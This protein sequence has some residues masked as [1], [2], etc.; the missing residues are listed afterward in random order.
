MFTDLVNTVF[1]GDTPQ[2]PLALYQV[3]ARAV[4]VYLLGLTVVRIGK[5]R[6]IGRVTPLD[7]LL[8]IILGSLLGRGMTGRASISATLVASA[9]IV[10]VHWLLTWAACYS[11]TFGNLVK[12]HS[13]QLV[14]DGRMVK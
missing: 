7:V 14:D 1:G 9:A 12:G 11:H 5:S 2:Q 13:I 10:A 4:V 8:A 3:A 6:M